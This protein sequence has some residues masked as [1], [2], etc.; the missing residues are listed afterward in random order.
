MYTKDNQE[1]PANLKQSRSRRHAQLRDPGKW[2][3]L[4]MEAGFRARN[5]TQKL[6]VSSRQ[7]R[8]VVSAIFGRAPEEVLT[9]WRLVQSKEVLQN[10]R[11]VKD[12][13]VFLDYKQTS[14]FSR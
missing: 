11:R 5:I 12:A 6:H 7:F 2:P 14:H 9:E 13:A 8:R 1:D 10:L 4:A 3:E